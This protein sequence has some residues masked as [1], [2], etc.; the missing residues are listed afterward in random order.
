[1]A[2]RGTLLIPDLPR[3]SWAARAGVA[4]CFLA[5]SCSVLALSDGIARHGAD[6]DPANPRAFL[7]VTSEQLRPAFESLGEWISDDGGSSV[8]FTMESLGGWPGHAQLGELNRICRRHGYDRIILGGDESVFDEAAFRRF[9]TEGGEVVRAPVSTLD[10]AYALVAVW[11]AGGIPFTSGPDVA[12]ESM[13]F[14]APGVS[15]LTSVQ[16]PAAP[17]GSTSR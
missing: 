5:F 12:G 6:P 15:V 8:L 17:G 1:M 10:E 9:V 3:R 16:V 4:L 13:E 11:Q 14:P 7:I 2:L